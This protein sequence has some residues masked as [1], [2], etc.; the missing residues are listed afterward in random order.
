MVIESILTCHSKYGSVQRQIRALSVLDGLIQNAGSRFQRA[1]ADEPLLERLRI[2]A[3]DDTVDPEVRQRCNILFRQWAI[4]Y[5]DTPGLSQIAAL[6]QQLPKARKQRPVQQYKS[7]RETEENLDEHD[8]PSHQPYQA[9]HARNSSAGGSSSSA[10]VA[11][12]QAPAI[13][14]APTPKAKAAVQKTS[15]DKKGRTVIKFHLEKEKPTIMSTMAQASV[16]S[17]NLMNGLQLVNREHQR[18]SE[19]PEVVNRFET[20]KLLR[21]QILRYIQLVET[22][23]LIGSLLNS[24][25]ELVKALTMYEIM[26]RSV[27]DDSDS[28]EWEK[29]DGDVGHGKHPMSESASHQLA[30]LNLNDEAPP[31]KPPRPAAPTSIPMPPPPKPQVVEPEV[32]DDDEEDEDDPFGDSHA[33]K[34]PMLERPGMT[35]KTV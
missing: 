18:V 4:A 29:P 1:F 11:T 7:I 12:L 28:D 25:D 27:D 5:K 9:T 10:A 13:G 14:L 35:W 2:L 26:D 15:K 19:N 24:N 20:C 21:R 34:T 31:A 17:T 33:A 6:A 8:E 23:E 32:D 3:R 22:E 16:A 30:G